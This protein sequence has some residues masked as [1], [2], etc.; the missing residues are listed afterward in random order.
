MNSALE[1][2][3]NCFCLPKG[4]LLN[5]DVLLSREQVFDSNVITMTNSFC[6]STKLLE[7]FKRLYFDLDSHSCSF[8]D[9]NIFSVQLCYHMSDF[10]KT[11][12]S[13]CFLGTSEYTDTT[14]VQFV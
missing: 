11:F 8:E 4:L 12:S 1:V 3:N 10:S 5:N 14:E 2:D 7:P 6:V 13:N 9:L